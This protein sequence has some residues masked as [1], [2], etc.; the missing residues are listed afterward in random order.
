MHISSDVKGKRR[1]GSSDESPAIA[2][3]EEAPA[4]LRKLDRA[5]CALIDD[6]S[7][8]RA[9]W[10][11]PEEGSFT[12]LCH[13]ALALAFTSCSTT[14][15]H[16]FASLRD[17]GLIVGLEAYVAKHHTMRAVELELDMAAQRGVGAG[18]ADRTMTI[19]AIKQQR[20]LVAT[21]ELDDE[22]KLV[23]NIRF[24]GS[25]PLHAPEAE[26]A[27][28]VGVSEGKLRKWL[29]STNIYL[30]NS[31]AGGCVEA[32]H[33]WKEAV[34]REFEGLEP[35]PICYAV[36]HA[37]SR[38]PPRLQCRQCRNKFHSACLY[39]WFTKSQKSNCPLCQ[40]PWGTVAKREKPPPRAVVVDDV[41]APVAA[42]VPV[43]DPHPDPEPLSSDDEEQPDL[44]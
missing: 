20:V 31:N 1:S 33:R 23:M 44:D 35:C 15:R 13:H 14:C 11:G 10:F 42:P 8:P 32:L 2:P 17:R 26:C 19:K 27:E 4:R 25:F 9:F 6:L 16:W 37:T 28:R 41:P 38:L 3:P 29:L 7:V 43:P 39:Q 34:D 24:P 21:C 36:I 18:S 12:Q 5:S 30:R 22:S 40:Q